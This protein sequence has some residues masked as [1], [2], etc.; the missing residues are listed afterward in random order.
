MNSHTGLKNI[1]IHEAQ[2]TYTVTEHLFRRVA[3]PDLSWKPS[4][5]NNWM[6]VGQLLMHCASYG[7]GK[8]VR[9]FV[10]NH[11]DT[12]EGNEATDHVPAAKALPSVASVEEALDLLSSDRT[13]TLQCLE[14]ASASDLLTK[15]IKAPWGGP[16]LTLFQHLSLMIRHLEQHK[17][18][19][20]YYLKLMDRDVNT[21]DLW[22]EG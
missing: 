22:G 1:L 2:T 4:T 19:L 8:A 13:L 12:E 3:D 18:Q 20:F 14:R 9:G 21:R 10:T 16:D 15:K 11:W 7:C 6:T 17:G 5:G